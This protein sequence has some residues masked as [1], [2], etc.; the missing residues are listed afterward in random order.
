MSNEDAFLTTVAEE[1]EDESTATNPNRLAD[2]TSRPSH[3]PGIDSRTA[4]RLSGENK[5][6]GRKPVSFSAL[7]GR[8]GQRAQRQAAPPEDTNPAAVA[9]IQPRQQA[10][11]KKGGIFS[12][13][14]FGNNGS[15]DDNI[16]NQS[17][18]RRSSVRTSGA[19][20][21]PLG[22]R[23]VS[24]TLVFA[25]RSAPPKP[26]P[27]GAAQ[28]AAVVQEQDKARATYRRYR[29]GD[30]VLVCNTPSRMTNLVNR[31]GYP[32]GGGVTSEEQRGPYIYVLATVKKVHFE[33]DAEYYT[34]TRVDTGM[35]QRADAGKFCLPRALHLCA[36]ACEIKL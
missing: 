14:S 30:S 3:D 32:T 26:A 12:K 2:S 7:T 35:D 9:P 8:K 23:A 15:L 18:L 25:K 5:K 16:L 1:A 20:R 33:E 19:P 21:Q 4:P 17:A 22:A 28:A 29:V 24:S 11:K 13:F 36:C 10:K 31:Y 6:A 27:A 34:V